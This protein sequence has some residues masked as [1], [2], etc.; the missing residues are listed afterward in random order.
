M[1]QL[2]ENWITDNNLDFEYKKY[3]L[4]AW[5]QNVEREF[6]NVHLYPA[7]GELV[8]HYRRAIQ[9]RDNANEIQMGFPRKL[10]GISPDH[11]S[12]EYY[13][14]EQEELIRSVV[15]ILTF[16][17]PHFKTWLEEGKNLYELL[18]NGIELEPVGI[19]PIR[20]SEGYL[21]LRHGSEG[22]RVYSY[23]M[24]IYTSDTAPWRSLKTEFIAD[25]KNTISN[26]FVSI[27][28]E[29]VKNYQALPNPAVYAAI[30]ERT[31]PVE[32]AFL[33]I[34]KRMLLRTISA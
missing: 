32:P 4:L 21:F 13:Q 19:V 30:T 29:L 15:R 5:L 22:T 16:S 24:T 12:L 6:R 27:K 17:I 25:W 18:E 26:S 3:V 34:A 31:L 20:N 11:L 2:S 10:V 8:A 28:S 14:E 1:K 9:L 33:P 7:L 23:E